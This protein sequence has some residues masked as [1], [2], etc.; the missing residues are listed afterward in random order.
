MTVAASTSTSSERLDGMQLFL[1]AVCVF[2][3]LFFSYYLFTYELSNR[4]TISDTL[5][6]H[7]EYVTILSIT[8]TC[9]MLGAVFFLTQYR[10]EKW[11]WMVAGYIGVFLTLMGWYVILSLPHSSF[12][13]VLK[14]GKVLTPGHPWDL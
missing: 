7:V 14:S 11:S 10:Y 9:R 5:F 2:D 4:N 13:I 3:I 6:T 1:L 8:L 12:K